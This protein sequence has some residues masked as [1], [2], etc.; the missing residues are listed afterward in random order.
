MTIIPLED[1]LKNVTNRYELVKLAVKRSKQLIDGATPLVNNING[2]K[3]NII[4]LKEIK[5]G[6]VIP[7]REEREQKTE[8]NK[9]E[10][11]DKG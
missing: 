6:K 5:E 9:E 8:D 10:T 2:D 4:A 7:K 3:V 11:E 1:L